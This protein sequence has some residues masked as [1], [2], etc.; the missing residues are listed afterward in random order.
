[1]KH[2]LIIG[3]GIGSL[4]TALMLQKKGYNVQVF[5]A[6]SSIEPVG[7]GLGIGSNALQALYKAGVGDQIEREGNRLDQMF[8]QNERGSHLNQM[9][10][11]SLAQKFGLNNITIHRAVLHDI[12]FEAIEP[13]TIHVNKRCVDFQEKEEGITVSFSDGSSIEASL[14]IAA[15]GIHSMFREKL[16]ANSTP[17]YAGYTCW[18][19]VVKTMNQQFNQ[20]TSYELWGKAGRIGIVPLQGGSA[21]WFACVNAKQKDPMYQNSSPEDVA[22]LFHDFPADVTALIVSTKK[23]EL[24]HHDISDIRPLDQFVFGRVVLLGDAAHATTPNMGQGA[25]QA[26]EDAIVFVNCL[27]NAVDF[28]EAAISYE[29]KRIKRTKK[30]I[31][32]SRQIGAA[33]QFE[34]GFAIA[35]RNKLFQLIPSRLLLERFRYLLDV[36]LT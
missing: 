34:N 18:R 31:K 32:M 26:L 1:M 29:E 28:R 23:D 25:G 10:F 20:Q 33:A 4:C 19:G 14:V 8:F 15:D 24:L 30:V 3:A 17:R 22:R 6:A 12:L 27:T 21:Y 13:G 5:E 7:A 2:I 16:I 11:T 9:D 35:I 36:D